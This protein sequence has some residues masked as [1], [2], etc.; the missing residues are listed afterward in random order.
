MCR[1]VLISDN[2]KVTSTLTGKHEGLSWVA[3]GVVTMGNMVYTAHVLHLKWQMGWWC[4]SQT[5]L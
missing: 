3:V 5:Q 2:G 1:A 4:Y